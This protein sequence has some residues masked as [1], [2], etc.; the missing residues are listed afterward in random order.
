MLKQAQQ[1]NREGRK[2]IDLHDAEACLEAAEA[3]VLAAFEAW[4]DALPGG[5]A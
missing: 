5:A 2:V 3:E 1:E 4:R